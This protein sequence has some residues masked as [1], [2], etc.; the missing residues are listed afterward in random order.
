MLVV[1]S[2]LA[3]QRLLGAVRKGVDQGIGNTVEHAAGEPADDRVVELVA[4]RELDLAR[5]GRQLDDP[6][7]ALEAP[8][9]PTL[10]MDR[11]PMRAALRISRGQVEVEPVI[12]DCDSRH[13]DAGIP[14]E[15]DRVG[16][17]GK[18]LWVMLRR[19]DQVEGACRGVAD[20]GGF[21]DFQR[22]WVDFLK[23]AGKTV[24]NP[25]NGPFARA[26][27]RAGSG[28]NRVR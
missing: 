26:P 15:D 9:R 12:I 18:E 14:R 19:F 1:A 2:F 13:H 24:D 5:L 3:N 4:Q 23:G 7:L 28:A 17:P 10:E 21:T 25:L 16:A 8:E 11:H 6:P 27:P 20:E 22:C